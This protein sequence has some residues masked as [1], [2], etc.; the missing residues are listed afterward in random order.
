ML[1][2]SIELTPWISDMTVMALMTRQTPVSPLGL[3][4]KSPSQ[5]F[6][7]FREV[8]CRDIRVQVRWLCKIQSAFVRLGMLL[9]PVPQI[10]TRCPLEVHGLNFPL[11]FTWPE[12]NDTLS[13]YRPPHKVRHGTAIISGLRARLFTGRSAEAGL[14]LTL[15]VTHSVSQQTPNEPL[16][17]F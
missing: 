12:L 2:M 5:T 11:I 4:T 17:D 6:C 15:S 10:R 14:D 1:V 8:S 7:D 13:F 16:R 3:K 9:P